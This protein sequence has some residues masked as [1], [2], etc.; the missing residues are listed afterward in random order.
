VTNMKENNSH[1]AS[2]SLNSSPTPF[3]MKLLLLWE[4]ALGIINWK[5]DIVSS[6]SVCN[7][8]SRSSNLF[9]IIRMITD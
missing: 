3:Q 4:I 7:H 2:F 5:Q 1:F 9:L 6:D 8:T